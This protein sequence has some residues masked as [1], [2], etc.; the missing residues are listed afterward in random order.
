MEPSPVAE[1]QAYA[2]SL[3]ITP[4]YLAQAEAAWMDGRV[5]LA[6][7]AALHDEDL[8]ALYLHAYA[9]LR[10]GKAQAAAR[11][12]LA[13]T[14]FDRR[15]ARFYVGLGQAFQHMREFGWARGAYNVALEKD[16]EHRI[17]MLLFAECTLFIDGKRTAAELFT[18]AI[19]AGARDADDAAFIERAKGILLQLRPKKVGESK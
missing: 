10:A 18:R 16:P 14:Q 5:E 4:D 13:L 6:R 3:G 8:H 15:Q 11:L 1:N 12:F 2:E 9:T 17:A 7:L 19:A